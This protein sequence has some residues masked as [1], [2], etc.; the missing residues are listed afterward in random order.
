[1]VADLVGQRFGKLTVTERIGPNRFRGIY[2]LCKCDCG[3][4]TKALTGDLRA[5]RIRS[6]GCVHYKDRQ[7]LGRKPT[8]IYRIWKN[9]KKR[10]YNKNDPDYRYYGY[11][12]IEVCPEWHEFAPFNAWAMANGYADNLTLDRID[13]DGNYEPQN[14][15][16]ATRK[17]QAQ[18]RRPNGSVIRNGIFVGGVT[19]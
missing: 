18:H 8:R 3:G 7:T 6:C 11:R 12:G 16:W 9:M 13:N 2:W 15:K 19:T 1:M 5:G 17:E 4:F 10:C 14:C